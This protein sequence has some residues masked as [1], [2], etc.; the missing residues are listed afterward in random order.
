MTALSDIAPAEARRMLAGEGLSLRVGPYAMHLTSGVPEL[1]D[2]LLRLYAAHPVEPPEAFHD[3]HAAIG[4]CGGPRRWISPQVRFRR[5]GEPLFQPQPRAHAPAVLEWG[6]N[7]CFSVAIHDHLVVHAAVVAREDGRAAILAAPPGAGKS[8][9]CAGLVAAGWRLLSDELCMISL[10]DGSLLPV[11]RPLNLKNRSIDVVSA[12]MPEAVFGP[13]IH[14][15]SKGTIVQMAP[16]ADSV[17]RAAEPA[18]AAWIVFPRWRGGDGGCA[19]TPV[20][21]GHAFMRLAENTFNYNVLGTTAF[22]TL[23][24]IIEDSAACD[25]TYSDLDDA[26]AAFAAL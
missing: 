26:V 17:R 22:E 2:T 11:P 23:A 4:P 21:K 20:G 6:L 13:R 16:P 19:M 9:L 3:I 24:A 10:T 8:T 5:D 7:W 14:G 18:R 25:F 1:A 12:R 15:T